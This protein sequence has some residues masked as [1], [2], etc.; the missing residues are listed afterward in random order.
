MSK[1][2]ASLGALLALCAPLA[3]CGDESPTMSADDPRR[4]EPPAADA[5]KE[6]DASADEGEP[7]E[8]DAPT[9]AAA[10]LEFLENG[11]YKS[12]PAEP[13][14]HDSS[15]PHGGGVRV[16]Y[17]P[18][19]AQALNSGRASFPAGAAT[20]KEL[21]SEGFLYGWAVWTKVQSASDGGKGFYWYEII[22]GDGDDQVYG[23]GLGHSDCVDCHATGHDFLLSDR[24]FE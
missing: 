9:N 14:Y 12:W 7:G 3:A 8:L 5:G 20:V 4:E 21:T 10:Y 11:R 16:F 1:I 6:G 23:D 18:K 24:P 19:A 17:S 2:S 13:D 15:G 22:R